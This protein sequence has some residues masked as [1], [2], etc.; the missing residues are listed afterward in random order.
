METAAVRYNLDKLLALA[1]KTP[2]WAVLEGT[3]AGR[4]C[5]PMARRCGD[6]GIR[7]FAGTEVAEA[8][9]IRGAL[10]QAEI[11]M[12]RPTADPEELQQLLDLDVIAT[13]SCSA[14]AAALN[15]LALQRGAVAEVHVKVDTGMGRDG[16]MT[17]GTEKILSVYRNKDHLASTGIYTHVPSTFCLSLK[18]LSRR[19]RAS[20]GRFEECR[21]R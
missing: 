7:R 13:I 3:G 18:N 21:Q 4:W 8:L 19:R 1:G 2:L 11:L 12:L 10:A 16:F 9:E 6:A 5:G 20:G 17:H 14:E 15:S